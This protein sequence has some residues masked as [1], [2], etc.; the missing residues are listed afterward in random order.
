MPEGTSS[1]KRLAMYKAHRRFS[2]R[3]IRLQRDTQAIRL[4]RAI[5]EFDKEGAEVSLP[6]HDDFDKLPQEKQAAIVRTTEITEEIVPKK[7]KRLK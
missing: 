5:E 1:E 4:Q 3:E 7:H 6:D 2:Q